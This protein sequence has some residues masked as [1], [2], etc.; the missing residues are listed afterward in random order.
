[1]NRNFSG[2]LVLLLSGLTGLLLFSGNIHAADPPKLT[3]LSP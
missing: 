1:M 2:I 3:W